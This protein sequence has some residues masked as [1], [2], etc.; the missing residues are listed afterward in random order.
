MKCKYQI[1][2]L[3]HISDRSAIA[4]ELEVVVKAKNG[5]GSAVEQL[6]GHFPG[7][8]SRLAPPKS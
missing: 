8:A 7:L 6:V 2:T 4:D 1:S 3:L 5:S